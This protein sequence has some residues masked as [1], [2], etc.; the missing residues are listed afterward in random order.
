MNKYRSNKKN[1]EEFSE[2][3]SSASCEKSS[4]KPSVNKATTQL[5]EILESPATPQVS[6]DPKQPS[7]HENSSLKGTPNDFKLQQIREI[8][9]LQEKESFNESGII[10]RERAETCTLPKKAEEKQLSTSELVAKVNSTQQEPANQLQ[11]EINEQV[12]LAQQ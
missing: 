7:E 4:R 8:R 5:T 11:T 2:F 6:A 10:T 9:H 1:G 12:G 3:T